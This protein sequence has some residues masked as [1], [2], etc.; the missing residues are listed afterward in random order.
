MMTKMRQAEL[1][2][3]HCPRVPKLYMRTGNTLA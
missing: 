1:L 3:D 2:R